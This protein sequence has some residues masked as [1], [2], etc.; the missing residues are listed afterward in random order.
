MKPQLLPYL[1]AVLFPAAVCSA[2]SPQDIA[3]TSFPSVAVL[4]MSDANQQPLALGSGFVVEDGVIVTN[5]HVIE[6]AAGGV[7]KL[8]G[9]SERL[10]IDGIL[11][12]DEVHDL[13][14][15]KVSTA[16]AV[17]LSLADNP[18]LLV[19]DTVYAVGNPQGLEGT[20]SQGIVSGLRSIESDQ[21]IQ[22]TAPISPGSSGG[23]VLNM[24]G[25]VIG[26]AV[27]TYREGQN[28][29]FAIP[30]SYLRSI[31]TRQRVLTPF[32]ASAGATKK[33]FWD[34][35]GNNDQGA[36][37]VSHVE[38]GTPFDIKFSVRNRT[39][40]ALVSVTGILIIYDAENQPIDSEDFIGWTPSGGVWIRPYL[41][42]T[43]TVNLTKDRWVAATTGR[44]EVRILSVKTQQE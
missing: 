18:K 8:L 43:V 20:F 17:P 4:V 34:A 15:V 28:L 5:N 39:S 40:Y 35:V 42:K 26:V 2:I 36:V 12:R 31:I 29:N 21:L 14:L 3:R 33:S 32:Q 41:A 1:L 44:I 27:A 6:G 9:H 10:Q 23:P 19:G 11:A 37:T 16:G 24:D 22:I 7:M 30:V 38:S 13:A 25:A